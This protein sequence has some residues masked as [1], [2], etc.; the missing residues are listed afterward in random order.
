MKFVF[1]KYVWETGGG[2][3]GGGWRSTVPFNTSLRILLKNDQNS[4]LIIN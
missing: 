1:P 3:G 4:A 2:G